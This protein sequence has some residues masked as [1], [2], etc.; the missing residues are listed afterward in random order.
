MTDSPLSASRPCMDKQHLCFGQL[1]MA[2]QSPDQ[3]SE[4][5]QGGMFPILVWFNLFE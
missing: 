2:P 3:I 4:F 5:N 1:A